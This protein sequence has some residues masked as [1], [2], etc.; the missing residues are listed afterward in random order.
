MY[1]LPCLTGFQK[2]IEKCY[3]EKLNDMSKFKGKYR[4]ESA[5]A[6]WWDYSGNR[7]NP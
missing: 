6:T 1:L 4:I 3:S 2:K 7:L 5:R